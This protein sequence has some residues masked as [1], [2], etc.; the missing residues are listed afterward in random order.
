MAKEWQAEETELELY[1]DNEA[2][3]Y[4]QKKAIIASMKK[5]VEHGE[6]DPFLAIKAWLYWVDAGAKR[7]CA[8]WKVP[9]IRTFPI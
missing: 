2:E 9:I 7:Y 3:L 5:K 1:I 4:P 8:E 6:Y